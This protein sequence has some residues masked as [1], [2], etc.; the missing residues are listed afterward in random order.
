MRH[1]SIPGLSYLHSK[2][3]LAEQGLQVLSS[4]EANWPSGQVRKHPIGLLLL[5][6]L[7]YLLSGQV[8]QCLS[9]GPKQVAQVSSQGSQNL[10]TSIILM[11][12]FLYS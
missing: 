8:E 7:I 3:A 1:V 10:G 6:Y 11:T 5:S 4:V 12:L 2:Q 9:V